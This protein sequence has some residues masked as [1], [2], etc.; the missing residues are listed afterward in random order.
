MK[1]EHNSTRCGACNRLM[2]RKAGKRLACSPHCEGL[3]RSALKARRASGRAPPSQR[4]L[5]AAG[6]PTDLNGN[7][8]AE[9][10][11]GSHGQARNKTGERT[12]VSERA[13]DRAAPLYI[14]PT[15]YVVRLQCLN[16]GGWVGGPGGR[17]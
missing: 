7:I 3:V 11:E 17:L 6:A 4:V 12:H 1:T 9:R 5:I 13:E 2:P 14:A 16:W 10:P 8:Q 15:G